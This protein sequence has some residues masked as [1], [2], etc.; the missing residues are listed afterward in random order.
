MEW[1]ETIDERR[2]EEFVACWEAG[3]AGGSLTDSTGN[4]L[5]SNPLPIKSRSLGL[6]LSSHLKTYLYTNVGEVWTFYC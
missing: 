4:K 3:R 6:C 2:R 5:S 1:E